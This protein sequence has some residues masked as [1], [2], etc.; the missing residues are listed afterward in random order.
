MIRSAIILLTLTLP[1]AA[2]TPAPMGAANK[3]TTELVSLCRGT[4]RDVSG[5][6]R[7]PLA[8]LQCLRYIEGFKD[9][10]ALIKGEPKFC[11][12]GVN[13]GD[14]ILAFLRWADDQ[15]TPLDQT[16]NL[17]LIKFFSETYPCKK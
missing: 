11:A 12:P 5:K 2:Q 14:Q 16:K 13:L 15:K 4:I 3:G 6:D 8:S 7:D 9:G 17:T 1:A 10:L